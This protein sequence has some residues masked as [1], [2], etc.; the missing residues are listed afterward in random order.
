V[1]H[2]RGTGALRE[3]INEELAAHPLVK[4]RDLAPANEGGDGATIA[5]L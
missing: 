3:V 1:I 5:T 2:G 4:G